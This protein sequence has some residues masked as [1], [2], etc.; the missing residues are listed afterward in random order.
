A[1]QQLEFSKAFGVMP[2]RTSALATYAQQ[3]PESKAWV[4]GVATSQPPVTIAGFNQVLTQFN[5]DLQSLK[6]G[7][8]AAVLGSLQRNGEQALKNA[9]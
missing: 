5:T 3:Y 4:D 1:D 8:P 9:K 6:T 2:S 7:D